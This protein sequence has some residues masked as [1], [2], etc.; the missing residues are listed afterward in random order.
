M[1]VVGSGDVAWAAEL[2]TKYGANANWPLKGNV[3]YEDVSMNDLDEFPDVDL[4][5]T[6]LA[7]VV[8]KQ[9]LPMARLLLEHGADVNEATSLDLSVN[10][11]EDDEDD[12]DETEE[13]P[14]SVALETGN[15]AIIEL[16][17]SKGAKSE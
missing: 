6:V 4:L 15:V 16:L 12:E 11:E 8:R 2:L 10:K 1:N 7:V 17:K 3:R 5:S 9:N 14:L 13:T